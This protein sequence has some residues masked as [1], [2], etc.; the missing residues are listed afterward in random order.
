[1]RVQ[2]L[3]G[4]R[5]GGL[6]REG[7]ARPHSGLGDTADVGPCRLLG[8]AASTVGLPKYAAL[9]TRVR[10]GA[11]LNSGRGV[12]RAGGADRVWGY[13][14]VTATMPRIPDLARARVRAGPGPPV[15]DLR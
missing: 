2:I 1:M 7:S 5:A 10:A 3:S 6:A 12:S 4:G 8:P 9:P 14:L 15:T 13:P 11:A